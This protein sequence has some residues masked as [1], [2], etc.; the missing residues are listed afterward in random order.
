MARAPLVS[1]RQGAAPLQAVLPFPGSALAAH[2]A[3]AFPAVIC[4]GE[5]DKHTPKPRLLSNVNELLTNTAI[6]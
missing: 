5:K 2:T 4:L 6:Y 3:A 1:A